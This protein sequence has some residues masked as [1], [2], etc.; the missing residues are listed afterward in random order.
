LWGGGNDRHGGGDI[1]SGTAPGSGAV[2]YANLSNFQKGVYDQLTKILAR[3]PDAKAVLLDYIDPTVP[4][5]EPAYD[6]LE[7][8]FSDPDRQRILFLR[9]RVTKGMQDACE[10]D[11]KGH[12]NV[13]LH[14]AWAAQILAWM[15]SKDIFGQFGF[16]SG[17]D[18]GDL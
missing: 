3:N 13:S 8:L 10:V 14:S 4:D 16:P 12:P 11:P 1:A 18:W 5:W 6:Q 7:T 9:V 17:E 2:T 15:L